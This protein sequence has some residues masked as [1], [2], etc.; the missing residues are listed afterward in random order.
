MIAHLFEVHEAV[1]S[2]CLISQIS[3]CDLVNIHDDP[4]GEDGNINT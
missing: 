1:I 3:S 4:V 2:G